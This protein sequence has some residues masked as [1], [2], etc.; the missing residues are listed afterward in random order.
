MTSFQTKVLHVLRCGGFISVDIPGWFFQ[1][2]K[3]R[4]ETEDALTE[5]GELV[6][7]TVHTRHRKYQ[8]Y[9]VHREH[10]QHFLDARPNYKF[11]KRRELGPKSE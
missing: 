6:E 10:V 1:N 4:V 3:L 5:T 8:S 9:V 2:R 11:I 7:L